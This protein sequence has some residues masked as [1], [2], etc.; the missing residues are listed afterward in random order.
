MAALTFVLKSTG[1]GE[2]NPWDVVSGHSGQHA[3]FNIYLNGNMELSIDLLLTSYH[4]L[5]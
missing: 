2:W 5:A 4:V 1:D 3:Y